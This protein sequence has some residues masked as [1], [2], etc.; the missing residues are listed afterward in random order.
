[1]IL[2]DLEGVL[3]NFEHR[4]HFVD[5]H[6]SFGDFDSEL[7]P[8]WKS[9]YEDC[10][11]DPPIDE[12]GRALYDFMASDACHDIEIWSGRCESVREKTEAWLSYHFPAFFH[13]SIDGKSYLKSIKMRPIGDATPL[14][15]LKEQ[16]YD[17]H[18]VEHPN[19][20]IEF[21]FESD[22]E[23]VKMWR[24]RGVFVF[25]VNQGGLGL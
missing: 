18:N 6:T 25:D 2:F 5:R 15:R 12:V 20:N 24:R 4:R 19:K 16:W 3:A 8:D 14:Y 11:D 17:M 7:Q 1:M 21:V 13:G 9:F 23:C 22:P 10:L